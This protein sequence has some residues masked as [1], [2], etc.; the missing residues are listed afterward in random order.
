VSC[1]HFAFPEIL[2][3]GFANTWVVLFPEIPHATHP[4]LYV[5]VTSQALDFAFI[6]GQVWVCTFGGFLKVRGMPRYV[7]R[8]LL[9]LFNNLYQ[10]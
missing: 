3:A 7:F 10:Y 6:D 9:Q 4:N 5:L 1:S 8:A 2:L